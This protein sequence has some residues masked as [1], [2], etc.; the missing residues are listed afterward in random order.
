MNTSPRQ[1]SFSRFSKPSERKGASWLGRWKRRARA[2]VLAA[3]VIPGVWLGAAMNTH[4]TTIGDGPGSVAFDCADLV[5]EGVYGVVAADRYVGNVLDLGTTE[6]TERIVD[7]GRNEV[8]SSREGSGG[9]MIY[10]LRDATSDTASDSHEDG[11][12]SV[13]QPIEPGSRRTSSRFSE[14]VAATAAAACASLGCSLEQLVEPWSLS[15]GIKNRS[16]QAWG[17]VAEAWENARRRIAT[18]TSV[19][20]VASIDRPVEE[21]GISPPDWESHSDEGFGLVSREHLIRRELESLA[22]YEPIDVNEADERRDIVDLPSSAPGNNDGS[23]PADRE[24]L[25]GSSPFIATLPI[26]SSPTVADAYPYSSLPFVDGLAGIGLGGPEQ[27]IAEMITGEWKI[28]RHARSQRK[29]V[30]VQSVVSGGLHKNAAP[31]PISLLKPSPLTE[32]YMPYDVASVD[33]PLWGY[34][35]VNKRP[36]CIRH[37]ETFDDIANVDTMARR[38]A[39]VNVTSREEEK[40]VVAMWDLAAIGRSLATGRSHVQSQLGRLQ[41]LGRSV[42]STVAMAVSRSGEF[43]ARDAGQG[44]AN[45]I[46]QRTV[47]LGQLA[48]WFPIEEAAAPVVRPAEVGPIGPVDPTAEIASRPGEDRKADR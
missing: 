16:S 44:V 12:R 25:V 29:T 1:R 17:L 38:W 8:E 31:K 43:S 37:Q 15:I 34:T 2:N 47:L 24:I 13:T 46:V 9:V 7:A 35:P 27:R 18:D 40:A 21:G 41:R 28:S 6:A 22:R 32:S 4:A 26:S 45:L 33:L 14:S 36:Y 11:F 19:T 20:S 3:M 5:H 23:N 42:G 39:A 48:T 10:V 30:N